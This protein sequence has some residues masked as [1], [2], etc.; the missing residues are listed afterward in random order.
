MGRGMGEG[1]GGRGGPGGGGPGGEGRAPGR[2]VVC[3]ALSANKCAPL[4]HP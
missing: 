4:G 2:G 3:G 1:P